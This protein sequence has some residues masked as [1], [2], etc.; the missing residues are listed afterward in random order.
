MVCSRSWTFSA[1]RIVLN[2]NPKSQAE[3]LDG[4]GRRVES[5]LSLGLDT[6]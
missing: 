2:P 1:A 6:A 3:I 4:A 5:G